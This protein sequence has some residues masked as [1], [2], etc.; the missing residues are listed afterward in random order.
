MAEHKRTRSGK[1][2]TR[3]FTRFPE[4]KGKIIESIDV[5]PDVEAITI[6]FED[7]TALSFDLEPRITV[8]P[9][10]SGWKTGD[11]QRIK[12]WPPVHSKT[13]TVSWL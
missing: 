6:L 1:R 4:V 13:S 10:L 9:E 7:K 2:R 5:D 8:F 3:Q 11:W 12:R